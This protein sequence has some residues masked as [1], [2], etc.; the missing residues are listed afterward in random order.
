MQREIWQLCGILAVSLT[1][2]AGACAQIQGGPPWDPAARE[3][4]SGQTPGSGGPTAGRAS[5]LEALD[6]ILS[7][8]R[9]P[10]FD[11]SIY[12]SIRAFQLSRLGRE[13]D[14][15]KDIAEMGKLLPNAWQVVMSSTMPELAGGGDRAA[16]LR[17]LDY[18]L[19]RKPGDPW[20]VVAQAQVHMQLADFNR[21]LGMLDG[22]VGAAAN[23][24]ESRSA[25][26][27]RGHANFNLGNYQQAAADFEGSLAGRTTL[28]SR[29]PVLLW[30]YAAQ[31]HTKQD[32]RA[33]LNKEVGNE[34]LYEWPGPIARFL[35]GKLS[36]GELEVAAE[37]DA[38]AKR[39]N[40][41]CPAAFFIA[42][43]ARRRGDKQRAR[44]QLQLTQ[45]RCPTVSELN[46][47]AASELK[48]L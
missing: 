26:F 29:L 16:A 2:S 12:L 33:A 41:K 42:M 36:A 40:G 23:P 20:L 4:N 18:G 13:A 6:K 28:K 15:Q 47:A 45:A 5:S 9:L 32:A 7:A 8:S 25:M 44:E 37:S 46:W 31:V 30:R 38:A 39:G 21:A 27:Y 11:R 14:S 1:V 43:E 22:A 24:A 19:Q 34:N 48:R 10:A 3:L 17:T 35:I